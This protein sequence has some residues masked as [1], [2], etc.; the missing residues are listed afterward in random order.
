L[1]ASLSVPSGGLLVEVCRCIGRNF[2]AW[3]PAESSCA[4]AL[5][6]LIKAVIGTL[7]AI[8][9]S[10]VRVQSVGSASRSSWSSSSC[11]AGF[12]CCTPYDLHGRVHHALRIL[13]LG[14]T[15]ESI[16]K[17]QAFAEELLARRLENVHIG[18]LL[19]Q[20]TARQQ[21]IQHRANLRKNG[22]RVQWVD[23]QL[24]GFQ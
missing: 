9:R 4:S 20:L 8:P 1:G 12:H 22:A 18:G 11:L 10:W 19:Q 15:W 17:A 24:L 7:L 6:Y 21:R 5:A 16:V 13:Q 23:C 14:T 3:H 2:D